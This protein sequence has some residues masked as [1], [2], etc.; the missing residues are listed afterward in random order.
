MTGSL[1]PKFKRTCHIILKKVFKKDLHE[2]EFIFGI[3]HRFG[4]NIIDI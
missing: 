3:S 4:E 1:M 2:Q